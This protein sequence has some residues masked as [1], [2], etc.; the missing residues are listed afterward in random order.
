MARLHAGV[1]PEVERNNIHVAPESEYPGQAIQL[2]V[3]T[4]R[5]FTSGY[6]DTAT[7]GARWVT[8]MFFAFM[9]GTLF[10]QLGRS[11]LD[12]SNRIAALFH[13]DNVLRVHCAGQSASPLCGTSRV[14]P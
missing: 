12:A 9:V 5:F 14:F 10:I 7:F 4:K 2:A 8:S 3:L 13:V 11:Q 6:R 1:V